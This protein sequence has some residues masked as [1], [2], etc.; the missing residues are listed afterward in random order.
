[1]RQC[2]RYAIRADSARPIHLPHKR[3]AEQKLAGS[4][5]EHI[6]KAVAIRLQQQLSRAPAIGRIGE[7]EWL[8][9]IPIVQVMRSELIIPAQLSGLRLE[10]QN[11]VRIE[12]GPFALIAVS[13]RIRIAD[14]PKPRIGFGVVRASEPGL[15]ASGWKR[16]ALPRLRFRITLFRYGPESP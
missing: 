1:R 8:R 2:L 16:L 3:L 11:A 13:G 12:V 4:S 6:Q 14:R 7:H 10:R 15:A 9:S 5:I